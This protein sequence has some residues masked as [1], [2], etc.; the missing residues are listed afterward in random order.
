MVRY[1]HLSMRRSV[2]L[3][4]ALLAFLVISIPGSRAESVKGAEE[5]L[6]QA[7]AE[8][9]AQ[10]CTGAQRKIDCIGSYGTVDQY[11]DCDGAPRGPCC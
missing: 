9:P 2:I 8:P 5:G 7:T 10:H 3:T 11:G 1:S 6:A 4:L